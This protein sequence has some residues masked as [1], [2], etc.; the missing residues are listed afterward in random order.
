ML[1]RPDVVGGRMEQHEIYVGVDVSKEFLDVFVTGDEAVIRQPNTE[2]GIKDI[3]KLLEARNPKLVVME[4]TGSF[5]R[6]LLAVLATFGIPAV[7]VNPRQVREFAR[8]MGKIEKTDAIDARVLA[9]FAERVRPAVRPLPDELTQQ[10]E[11]LLGRRRQIVEMLTA[12]KN[13]LQ[14][15]QSR[16]V[17]KDLAAHIEWL[18][19]RLRDCD[20][21][22]DTLVEESPSWNTKTDLLHALKGIGRVTALTLLSAVPELGTLNRKQVAKLVG[23]AP[24]ANDSGRQKGRRSVWGGRAAARAVLYMATLVATRHNDVIKSF[25]VRLVSAGKLKKVALVA[26]MRKLLTIANAVVRQHLQ[27]QITPAAMG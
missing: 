3:R 11:E 1:E 21:D 15:A 10:F 23:V 20:G 18:K 8:A 19:K 5:G 17:Q 25:Y 24:L 6:R 22:L 16:R 4:A 26:C 14:Q 27:R 9:L 2:A 13:R 12:E 7:A